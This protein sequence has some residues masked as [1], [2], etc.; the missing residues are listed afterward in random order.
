M[1][2]FSWTAEHEL[3][4]SRSAVEAALTPLG[5]AWT[6]TPTSQKRAARPRSLG[7]CAAHRAQAELIGPED[8]VFKATLIL[9][10]A[11]A[12]WAAEA[13][14]VAQCL[15]ILAPLW[16]AGPAWLA[17]QLAAPADT[18]TRFRDLAVTLRWGQSGQRLVLGVTWEPAA[19]A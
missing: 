11:D 4:Q 18:T 6:R 19:G 7:T 10:A 1:P 3:V 5:F 14:F 13:P 2:D 9:S 16:A 17:A 8:M 12:G 15:A